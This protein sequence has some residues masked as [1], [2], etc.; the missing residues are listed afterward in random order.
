M[1]VI[2]IHFY[3]LLPKF[4]L[5]ELSLQEEMSQETDK[6]TASGLK[7]RLVR[8]FI[9]DADKFDH[10]PMAVVNINDKARTQVPNFDEEKSMIDG[11]LIAYNEDFEALMVDG[12]YEIMK[13][14]KEGGPVKLC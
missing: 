7:K 10:L 1:D 13:T 8:N 5:D 4:D 11:L 3:S 6:N 14:K 2:R 9:R 12:K